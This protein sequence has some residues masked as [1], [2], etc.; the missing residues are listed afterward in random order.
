VTTVIRVHL[1]SASILLALVKSEQDVWARAYTLRRT[2][3]ARAQALR[4]PLNVCTRMSPPNRYITNR[5]ETIEVVTKNRGRN[6]FSA[7]PPF[8]VTTL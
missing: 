7:S 5:E 2:A 1:G 3:F 6:N 8:V 4:T